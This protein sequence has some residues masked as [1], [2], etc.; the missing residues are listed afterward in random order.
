VRECFRKKFD[1]DTAAQP[2]IRGLIHLAHAAGSQ[3][4]GDLVVCELGSDHGAMKIPGGFYQSL[5]DSF[6][7]LGMGEEKCGAEGQ[8]DV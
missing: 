2:G 7:D 3:M 8:V 6:R 5:R 4:A 1:R